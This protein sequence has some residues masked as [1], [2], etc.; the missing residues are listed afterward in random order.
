M[1]MEIHNL[2]GGAGGPHV[3]GEVFSIGAPPHFSIGAP[4]PSPQLKPIYGPDKYARLSHQF[5]SGI[6][7]YG[8]PA[9]CKNVFGKIA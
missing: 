2:G 1:R 5:A 3:D 7:T 8:I 4:V 6:D 9:K